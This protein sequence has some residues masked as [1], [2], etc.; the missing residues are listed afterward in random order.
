M[1]KNGLRPDTKTARRFDAIPGPN[2]ARR[3]T[4]HDGDPTPPKDAPPPSEPPAGD[5]PPKPALPEG[6]PDWVADPEKA[7]KEIRKLRA[8]EAKRRVEAK[9]PEPAKEPKAP[10]ADARIADLESKWKASERRALIAEI[11]AEFGLPKAL[12]ARLQG[13]TEEELR[14]DAEALKA[15]VPKDEA[16]KD[17]KPPQTPPRGRQQQTTPV[18]GGPPAGETDAQKRQRLYGGGASAFSGGGVKF[19]GDPGDLDQSVG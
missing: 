16:P 17:E 3:R 10:D 5:K 6:A 11:A 2:L 9:T 1:K 18:P 4:W 8:A 19:H 13:E 7:W 12:A 15:F 14:E